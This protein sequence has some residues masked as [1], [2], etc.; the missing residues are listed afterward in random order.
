M[1]MNSDISMARAEI[2]FDLYGSWERVRKA[3]ARL[4]DNERNENEAPSADTTD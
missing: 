2:A 1:Q 3:A 4:S